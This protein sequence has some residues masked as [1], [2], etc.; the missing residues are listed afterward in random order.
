GA[1]AHFEDARLARNAAVFQDP[2]KGLVP[3]C[4]VIAHVG[5]GITAHFVAVAGPI[6]ETASGGGLFSHGV[7][8][9]GMTK[10]DTRYRNLRSSNSRT[11][12]PAAGGLRQR[13]RT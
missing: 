10:D 3:K 9:T 5:I 13:A 11:V 12:E 4:A 2:D 7:N 8:C 1:A 6:I